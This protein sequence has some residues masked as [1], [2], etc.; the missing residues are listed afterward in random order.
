MS[1]AKRSGR[2]GLAA[3]D[4]LQ[5]AAELKNQAAVH[6]EVRAEAPA[7]DPLAASAVNLRKSYWKLLRKVAEARADQHGGRPSVSKVIERLIDENR[8]AL[9]FETND[10]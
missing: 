5:R 9:E 8:A 1:A 4:P 2:P 7:N 3:F 6:G 10:K